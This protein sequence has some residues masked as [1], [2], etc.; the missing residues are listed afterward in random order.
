MFL[1]QIGGGKLADKAAALQCLVSTCDGLVFVGSMAFQIM[2]ALGVPVP[3][4]LVETGALED[5]ARIVESAKSR[6]IPLVLPQDVWCTIDHVSE[7]MQIA[8]VH[9]IPE[10]K[11]LTY[12][13]LCFRTNGAH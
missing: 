3:M 6:N 2:H 8:S 11:S 9:S 10:S 13:S 7:E 5:A 12:R 4:K 1:A